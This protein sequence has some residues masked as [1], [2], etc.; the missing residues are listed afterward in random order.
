MKRFKYQS[1]YEATNSCFWEPIPGKYVKLF[2]EKYEKVLNGFKVLDLGAGEGKNA[3]YLA[4]KGAEIEAIDASKVA[5]SRFALQ[6]DYENVKSRIYVKCQ[7]V[8][9][10]EYNPNSF[11]IV[12]AY[13][14]FH[15]FDSV[16]Q[17][18]GIINDIWSWLKKNGYLIIVTF[19]N[20][21]HPPEVQN[22]LDYNAFVEKNSFIEFLKKWIIL[23]VEEEIIE[24]SHPP[25]FIKHKHSLIRLIIQKND[26][27]QF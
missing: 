11:D 24:E 5:L 8:R 4:T 1:E 17:I 27:T 18:Y 22:Y 26:N 16:E 6:P 15:T 3:V 23:E 9:L 13:G 7:D 12:V 25:N 19:T 2:V 20:D 21:L 14:I 10:L